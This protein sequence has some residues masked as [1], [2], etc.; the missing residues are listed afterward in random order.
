[1]PA[2]DFERRHDI[3]YIKIIDERAASIIISRWES[4][5]GNEAMSCDIIEIITED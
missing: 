3:L 5:F 2:T 4:N 1:M